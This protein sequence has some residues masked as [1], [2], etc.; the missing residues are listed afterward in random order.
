[1]SMR[2]L[3]IA[4]II[5][6]LFSCSGKAPVDDS[7]TVQNSQQKID[8]SSTTTFVIKNTKDTTIKNGESIKYYKNGNIKMRGM[9][10]DGKREGL[11]KSWYDNAFPWSETEF[12]EG[13]KNGKTVTWYENKQKRYEGFYT[14]DEESGHWTY[15]DQNG[16]VVAS[17]DY[18]DK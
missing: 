15:W 14:N 13:I 12:K 3:L 16:K 11:W 9:M 18:D 5:T 1:M 2:L 8:T 10:K 4:L 17:K 7:I 6:T